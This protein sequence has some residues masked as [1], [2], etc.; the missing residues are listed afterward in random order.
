MFSDL[1][2]NF[3]FFLDKKFKLKI[4]SLFI[5]H[6]INVILDLVSV[7]LI[8][9]ILVYFFN[10]RDIEVEI[11]IIN[12]ILDYAETI[13][14]SISISWLL[15]IILIFFAIKTI[16]KI[17]YFIFITKF[18]F[19]LNVNIAGKIAKKKLSSTYQNHLKNIYSNF[20]NTITN[21]TEDFV[22]N[23][24]LISYNI[25]VNFV[26]L[27]L[28]IFFLLI[29]NPLITIAIISISSVSFFTFYIITKKK[30]IFFGKHKLILVEKTL[31][32]IKDIYFSFKEIKIY[33]AE[34]FFLNRFIDTKKAWASNKLKFSVV[35]SMPKLLLEFGLVIII[36]ISLIISFILKI[37]ITNIIINL[38]IFLISAQRIFP[39]VIMILKN[40]SKINYT[41]KAQLILLNE[42][43]QQTQN[44]EDEQKINFQKLISLKNVSYSYNEKKDVLEN[45]DLQII[46]NSFIGIRGLS[47]QG[48]S[49]LINIIMG[50]LSPTNGKVFIDN[51][52][53]SKN[54]NGYLN[55]ISYVPQKITIIDDSIR[56]NLLFGNQSRKITD[57]EIYKVLNEVK[58][59]RI[60]NE[61]PKKLDALISETTI[62]ASEGEIQ[63]FGIARALLQKKQI[64]ILDEITSSLDED[65]EN[66]IIELIKNVQK[67]T[68][69]I[70]ISHKE[71][72]LKFCDEIIELN[73]KKI[74]KIWTK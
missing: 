25:I 26:T 11:E 59:Q 14:H 4:I 51:L 13:I 22:Q 69:V 9:A 56:N 61:H 41:K 36:F 46:K 74:K 20:F 55:L 71:S 16:L 12:K 53:V 45:I 67:N 40:F 21:V 64:L 72:S 57:H 17:V 34:K 50:I 48:K 54:L 1:I 66:N 5:V 65:N 38:T 31:S 10:N 23:Y 73:N 58:I 68:T 2:F 44:N 70:M 29:V 47:G 19:D 3:K 15:L 6:I 39:A 42:F 63:R 32:K 49:T 43:N 8:P 62:K 24:F 35:S 33:R 37:E 60:I 30:F 18:G 52:E 27:S 7:A 28:F